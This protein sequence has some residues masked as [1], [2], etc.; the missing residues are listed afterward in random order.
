MPCRVI[1]MT[2]N[3]MGTPATICGHGVMLGKLVQA[4]QK[5]PIGRT[6]LPRIISKSR[7]SIGR[8]SCMFGANRVFVVSANRAQPA[9]TPTNMLIKGRLATPGLKPLEPANEMGYASKKR[10][11][12][13]SHEESQNSMS[14]Q[15][16][17]I[18]SPKTNDK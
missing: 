15:L 11:S 9:N 10:K 17:Q 14:S 3:P 13:P 18:N 1:T 8:P 5:R 4:N 12:S 7:V 16:N 2:E 6:M